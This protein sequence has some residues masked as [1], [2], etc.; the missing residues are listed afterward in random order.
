M[1][2]KISTLVDCGFS[3][4]MLSYIVINS[5]RCVLKWFETCYMPFFA[6]MWKIA[7]SSTICG[8]PN[9]L[10]NWSFWNLSRA[11]ACASANTDQGWYFSCFQCVQLLSFALNFLKIKPTGNYM[12]LFMLLLLQIRP[13]K[14][15]ISFSFLF[16]WQL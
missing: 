15:Y 7:G 4:M 12:C 14:Q 9:L 11:E 2:I 10:G 13:I 16:H 8:I 6:I 3:F 5:W 1:K